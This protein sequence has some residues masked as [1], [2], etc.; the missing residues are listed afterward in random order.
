MKMEVAACASSETSVRWVGMDVK[1]ER[2]LMAMISFK[3]S[4]TKNS[5][6]IIPPYPVCVSV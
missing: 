4:D 3:I 1:W 5:G 6:K 2:V